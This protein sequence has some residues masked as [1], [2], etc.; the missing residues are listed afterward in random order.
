MGYWGS[1]LHQPC[2]R[3]PA[4]LFILWPLIFVVFK[5]KQD[6]QTLNL[7]AGKIQIEKTGK[8]RSYNRF[9]RN[10]KA[11]KRT[12]TLN[13]TFGVPDV[14]YLILI[15]STSDGLPVPPPPK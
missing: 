8:E 9:L 7:D 3:Q 12:C 2:T 10:M 15:S 14:V 11:L 13:K 5:D 1:N 6:W 4:I